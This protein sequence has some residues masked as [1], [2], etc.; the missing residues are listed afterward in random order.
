MNENY[1]SFKNPDSLKDYKVL[2]KGN[3]GTVYLTPDNKALKLFNQ[4][5]VCRK[6]YLILKKVSG[7]DYFPKVYEYGKNYIIRDCIEGVSLT[8]YIKKHGLSR[9]LS[10]E[11]IKLLQAFKNLNFTK[12]DTRCRDIFVTHDGSLMSIDPKNYYTKSR[13]YPRHLCKGLKKLGVLDIFMDVLKSEHPNLYK[14]WSHKVY[15]YLN[16]CSRSA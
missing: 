9:E 4:V 11:I 13:N 6:E 3:N 1:N 7:N 8:E 5:Q 2:G 12:L 10:I 15:R 14:K 16:K